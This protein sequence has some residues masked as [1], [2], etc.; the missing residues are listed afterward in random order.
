MI[1]LYES[2]KPTRR[3]RYLSIDNSRRLD[4]QRLHICRGSSNRS[5]YPRITS[6]ED[7]RPIS[8]GKVKIVNGYPGYFRDIIPA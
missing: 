4:T 2:I 8:E 6:K 1:S 5:D 7:R 3:S